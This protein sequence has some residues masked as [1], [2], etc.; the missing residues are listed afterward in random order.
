MAAMMPAVK[1]PN[2]G[3]E[4]VRRSRRR[5]W[6]SYIA[7]MVPFLPYRCLSCN[8]RFREYENPVRKPVL[9]GIAV[10]TLVVLM[11]VATAVIIISENSTPRF[12][13]TPES[14]RLGASIPPLKS[15]P[16]NSPGIGSARPTSP[17]QIPI[18]PIDRVVP[19]PIV[20]RLKASDKFRVNWTPTPQGLLITRLANGPL[21]AAGL[22]PN[23][24][25]V[26][27]DGRPLESE[28]PLLKARDEVFSGRL[29]RIQLTIV[30]RGKAARYLLKKE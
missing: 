6:E 30:H 22:L 16:P 28:L 3:S 14:K 24:L 26:A 29:A 5:V 2:C 7:T 21:K 23:D 20:I 19:P 17:E 1:C 27:L 25:I 15:N 11:G 18:D 9:I 12:A 8:F 4:A 13:I 10:T